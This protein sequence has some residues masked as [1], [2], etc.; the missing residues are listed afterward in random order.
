V[1]REGGR[2]R[3]EEMDWREKSGGRGVE[4]NKKRRFFL[5]LFPATH[6][7]A[8]FRNQC[9]TVS[10]VEMIIIRNVTNADRTKKLRTKLRD[11]SVD[12][13]IRCATITKVALN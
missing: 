7:D 5:S 4:R 6:S 11:L 3:W 2:A 8:Q 10:L 9:S 1:N 13:L 12:D